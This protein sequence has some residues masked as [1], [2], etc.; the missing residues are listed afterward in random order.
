MEDF[1][2]W[3]VCCR[4]YSSRQ[5]IIDIALFFTVHHYTISRLWKQFLASQTAVWRPVSSRTRFTIL[6]KD[7]YIAVVAKWNQRLSSTCVT[8]MVAAANDKTISATTVTKAI[9]EWTICPVTPSLC[10]SMCPVQRGTIKV[11][12]ATC[13]LEC[14]W[15]ETHYVHGYVKIWP[16]TTWQ[17]YNGL[18]RTRHPQLVVGHHTFWDRSI[19]VWLG[20]LLLYSPAHL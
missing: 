15:L 20:I 2:C 17:A 12:S 11:V 4:P 14:V 7:Q 10:S 6:G 5:S 16:T 8:S 3:L 1:E 18:E 19:M 13:D 9:H